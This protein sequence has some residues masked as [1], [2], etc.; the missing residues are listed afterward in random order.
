MNERRSDAYLR[1]GASYLSLAGDVM[2]EDAVAASKEPRC[3]PTWLIP[4]TV[5]EVG[6]CLADTV[7]RVTRCPAGVIVR[8]PATE[9][10]S[11][12]AVS[13]GVD[14]RLLGSVVA[15]GSAV[16]RA[17]VGDVTAYGTGVGLL[18]CER[19]DRRQRED[20]GVAFS[21]IDGSRSIG[22]IV[23]FAPP[24]L[25]D[26]WTNDTWCSSRSRRVG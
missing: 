1:G 4:Q 13:V 15:P 3:T 9:T 26:R 14:R 16:G 24:E 23:V 18:G 2:N 7:R 17:C 10:A 25:D 11:I 6:F 20:R 22:A 19:R 21:L 5:E 12:V 8:D